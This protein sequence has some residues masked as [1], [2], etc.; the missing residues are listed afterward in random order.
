MREEKRRENEI[1]VKKS[2]FF[3]LE[4]KRVYLKHKTI[5][6]QWRGLEELQKRKMMMT[7]KRLFKIQRIKIYCN[8]EEQEE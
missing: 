3:F 7:K 8:Q 2:F 1:E 4:I 5:N 6:K